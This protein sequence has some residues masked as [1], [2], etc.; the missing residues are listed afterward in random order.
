MVI[1]LLIITALPFLFVIQ[2]NYFLLFRVQSGIGISC[3][4][5][6]I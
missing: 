4:W 3:D 1:L 5:L 2:V 6:E